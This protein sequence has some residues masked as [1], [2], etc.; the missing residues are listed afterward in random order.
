M[1]RNES[2]KT[3]KSGDRETTNTGTG[4]TPDD[5]AV[6]VKAL[7]QSMKVMTSTLSERMTAAITDLKTCLLAQEKMREPMLQSNQGEVVRSERPTRGSVPGFSN[8][9]PQ[10]G[11]GLG[12]GPGAI[13]IHLERYTGINT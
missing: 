13:K 6:L 12:Q 2:Q 11:L 4:Q 8:E 9:R 5:Q 10:F 7:M 3:G 1:G